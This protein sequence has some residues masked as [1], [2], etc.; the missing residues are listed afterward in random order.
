MSRARTRFLL[1]LPTFYHETVFPFN[2]TDSK[3]FFL[4]SLSTV[5]V[6]VNRETQ[7]DNFNG[8]PRPLVQLTRELTFRVGSF[9]IRGEIFVVTGATTRHDFNL[10]DTAKGAYTSRLRP[11][12]ESQSKSLLRSLARNTT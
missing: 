12:K 1:F 7:L 2:R 11:A 10:C 8:I 3:T 5:L 9:H 4:I 6:T